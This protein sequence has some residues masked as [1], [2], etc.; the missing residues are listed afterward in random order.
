M[1]KCYRASRRT[2]LARRTHASL[3]VNSRR[4]ITLSYTPSEKRR[5]PAR[6]GR[7][8]WGSFSLRAAGSGQRFGE[9]PAAQAGPPARRCSGRVVSGG[10]S[11]RGG[12]GARAWLGARCL[13]PLLEARRWRAVGCIRVLAGLLLEWTVKF[14]HSVAPCHTD[15][16][17][18]SRGV[19]AGADA[20]AGRSA[21]SGSRST[22]GRRAVG[23]KCW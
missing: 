22:V 23:C 18:S 5:R 14:G 19:G 10:G 6:A 17:V 2:H 7:R 20:P 1:R 12:G 13:R 11:G 21:T 4:N 8:R 16:V 3:L 15:K 9:S